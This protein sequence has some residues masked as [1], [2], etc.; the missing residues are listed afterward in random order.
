[1]E[2]DGWRRGGRLEDP[3]VDLVADF[4]W[5]GGKRHD[6]LV[7]V[8][9]QKAGNVICRCLI[10]AHLYLPLGNIYT[11]DKWTTNVARAQLRDICALAALGNSAVG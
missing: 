11:N 2:D 6:G 3:S 8:E 7:R 10:A 9:I 5:K 4:S 1:M